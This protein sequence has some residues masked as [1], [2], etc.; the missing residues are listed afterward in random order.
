[1]QQAY[2]GGHSRGVSEDILSTTGNAS[3]TRSRAGTIATAGPSNIASYSSNTA[4]S[5]PV[6]NGA[7]SPILPEEGSAF[8]RKNPWSPTAEEVKKLGSSGRKEA[9]SPLES[10]V[11]TSFDS[12]DRERDI[13]GLPESGVNVDHLYNQVRS[14]NAGN[15]RR[16]TP[17]LPPLVTNFSA[18]SQ[19]SPSDPKPT[20]NG[21]V[22]HGPASASAYV[23]P[24]GHAHSN[25]KGDSPFNTRDAHAAARKNAFTAAPGLGADVWS[26]EK[27]RMAG[28]RQPDGYGHGGRQINNGHNQQY[29][30]QPV[31]TPP[32]HQHQHYQQPRQDIA[33][34][35][36]QLTEYQPAPNLWN[37]QPALYQALLANPALAAGLQPLPSAPPLVPGLPANWLELLQASMQATHLGNPLAALPLPLPGMHPAPG[38]A[39]P[40]LPPVPTH[41]TNVPSNPLDVTSLALRKNYNPLPGTFDLNP[42]NARFFVIKSYTEEDVHK[43]SPSLRE[44]C[45]TRIR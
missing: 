3:V 18:Q 39:N 23:P 45:Q 36:Q 29:D 20:H 40:G 15:A 43:V 12:S 37:P 25:A 13:D 21:P 26:Q 22:Y 1:M 28:Q 44:T 19:S 35:P 31:H 4:A 5:R 38:F 42:P 2:G 7:T 17:L 6:A 10:P 32:Q 34:A 24:I 16:S 33:P 14:N 41:S 27:E 11:R 8:R 30:H 9:T